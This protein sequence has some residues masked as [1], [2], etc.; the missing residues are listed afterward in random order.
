MAIYKHHVTIGVVEQFV[1]SDLYVDFC[2]T[3]KFYNKHGMKT[4]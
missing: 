2:S 4:M 3:L 1:T